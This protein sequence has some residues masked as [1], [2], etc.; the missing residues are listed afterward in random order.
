MPP[1]PQ[2]QGKHENMC[3]KKVEEGVAIIQNFATI[4]K[5][6]AFLALYKT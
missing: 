4:S 5:P 2:L 3:F 6:N 1:P